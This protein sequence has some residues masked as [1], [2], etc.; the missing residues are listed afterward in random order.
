MNLPKWSYTAGWLLIGL[1][2]AALEA[3]ALID[4]DSGDTLSEHVWGLLD[5][6]PLLWFLGAGFLL[7]LS[8]HF[9]F[10]KG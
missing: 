7:W 6:H 1:L 5:F 3:L 2:F 4:P 10:K 9:L 8:R